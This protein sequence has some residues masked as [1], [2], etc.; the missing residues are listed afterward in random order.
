MMID[1]KGNIVV[2]TDSGIYHSVYPAFT[3]W[4]SVSTGMTARDFPNH[5]INATQV[6]QN[7]V[8]H[9]FYA[10]SRGLSVFQSIPDFDKVQ[11][12]MILPSS[13]VN[14]YPNPFS[15]LTN[16]SFSL[17]Q[18]DAVRLDVYD[19]L[20]RKIKT[21]LNQVLEEGNHV[22]LLEGS[23]FPSG[24]YMTALRIGNNVSTSWITL[25]R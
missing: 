17:S 20:G 2:C 21:L 16:I 4:E 19:I 9:R 22:V 10:A 15:T 13:L 12:Q 8:D 5:Y 7:K 23:D 25:T 18:R 6:A 1:V 11:N 3:H 24:N 14:V